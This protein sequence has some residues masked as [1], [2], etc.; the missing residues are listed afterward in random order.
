MSVEINASVLVEQVIGYLISLIGFSLLIR[1]SLWSQVL[2]AV[3]GWSK[4]ARS[5]FS[6]M[7]AFA[8]LPLAMVIILV[9]SEWEWSFAVIVT[10]LGW[11]MAIKIVSLLLFPDFY[12]SYVKRLSR[13]EHF[14]YFLKGLG[15][16]YLLLGLLILCPYWF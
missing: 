6:V 4:E 1:T 13:W 14:S 2:T 10:I 16:L 5:V 8:F 11:L 15:L 9:H 12:F 3:N 7:S